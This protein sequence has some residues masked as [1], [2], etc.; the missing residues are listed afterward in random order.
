VAQIV[1]RA[2]LVPGSGEELVR[3]RRGRPHLIA[4][5]PDA[6]ARVVGKVVEQLAADDAPVAAG[7]ERALAQPDRPQERVDVRRAQRGVERVGR[8]HRFRKLCENHPTTE[9]AA[10]TIAMP[11]HSP[12]RPWF[13]SASRSSIFRAILSIVAFN[14]PISRPCDSTCASKR[15]KSRI[16]MGSIARTQWTKKIPLEAGA[17]VEARAL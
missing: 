2:H 3:A 5:D 11:A 8:S 9:L 4:L 14:S 15:P 1:L 13:A 7:V 12:P 16:S 17:E 10:E 6:S